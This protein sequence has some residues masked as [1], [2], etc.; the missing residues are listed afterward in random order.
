MLLQLLWLNVRW[1]AVLRPTHCCLRQLVGLAHSLAPWGFGLVH[2]F[3][4]LEVS[5]REIDGIVYF[6]RAT[7]L[8]GKAQTF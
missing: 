2:G 4:K 1:L 8:N 7:E 5:L 3:H 6:A